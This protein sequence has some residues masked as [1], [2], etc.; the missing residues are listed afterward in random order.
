[1]GTVTG[2]P[3]VPDPG[4]HYQFRVIV[5]GDAAVGKSSLLRCFAE[6]ASGGDGRP[7]PHRW[8]GVLQPHRSAAARRQGQAAALG[9]GRAGEVQIHHQILLP[10]RGG[11]AAGVRPHQ[12]SVLRARPRVVP[13]SRR[14]GAPR[15]RPGGP[16]PPAPGRCVALCL[17]L[18]SGLFQAL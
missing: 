15:L 18:G 4:G 11:G 14:G 5:L 8:R 13:R 9:H 2:P 7:L 12:P 10:E 6:G 3:H 16:Q 1:M 17:H